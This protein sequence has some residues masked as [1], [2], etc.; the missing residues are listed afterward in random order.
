MENGR[1]GIVSSGASQI[2]IFGGTVERNGRH[3][4]LAINRSFVT[5]HDLEP[6]E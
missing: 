1:A 5:T 4:V 2:D 6:K 3:Q